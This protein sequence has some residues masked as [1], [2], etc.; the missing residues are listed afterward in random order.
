M[1]LG[2]RKTVRNIYL[3]ALVCDALSGPDNL[4]IKDLPSVPL[5]ADQVRVGI[6]AAA[7]NFPDILM[8]YGKYQFK[9]AL[10]FVPGMEA[11]G[12][13]I[14]TG[15]EIT[16][17]KVGDRVL[18]KSK[19]GMFAEEAVMSGSE[20]LAMPKALSFEQGAAF[21]VAYVTAYISLLHR[22]QI[23]AG[24]TV[25]VHGAGGGVG[26]AAV[27]VAKW[28]GAKVIAVA[29][30]DEKL[31]LAKTCGADYL[32][33]HREE[34]FVERVKEITKGAGA[35]IIYDPVGGSV[36]ERSMKCINWGGRLLIV[37]FASGD[38]GVLK[39]NLAL[40]KGC[41]IIGVRAG[42]F[43]RQNPVLGRQAIT[44]ILEAAA[45]GDFNPVVTRSW[46]L[47]EAVTALKNMEE[48]YCVGKNCIVFP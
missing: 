44:I 39:T 18:A 13:V 14:E 26:A 6:K 42:E 21:L 33:N 36:F 16:D 22:G 1:V 4:S 38:F 46:K 32:I 15:S 27:D 2:F 29:S 5:N 9:P 12:E 41:S 24:E 25:L 37:G 10:P 19:T 11:A 34:N 8:T 7:L 31:Q 40:L 35:D 48:G 28:F 45:S 20:L 3:K 23:K 30:T 47:Q 17:W 43:S